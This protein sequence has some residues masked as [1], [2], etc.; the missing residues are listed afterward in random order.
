MK[1]SWTMG[2]LIATNLSFGYNTHSHNSKSAFD[3]EAIQDRIED[4]DLP[5]GVQY[6][7]R[8]EKHLK[9][10]LV[11]GQK[12]SAYIL[13]RSQMYFPIFEHYLASNTF[14]L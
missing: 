4:M 10:Y 8:V 2:F 3:M 6:N 13:K 7:F 12:Q 9:D 14:L 5:F 11:Y 1:F